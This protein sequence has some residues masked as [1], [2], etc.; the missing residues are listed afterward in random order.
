MVMS[1]KFNWL[2]DSSSAVKFMFGWSVLKSSCM[3]SM[4]M[5]QKS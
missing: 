5:W 4:S 1:R 3:S 2:L